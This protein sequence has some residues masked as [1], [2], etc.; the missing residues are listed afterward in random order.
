MGH[1]II[2]TADPENIKAILATQ[3]Q[4]YGKGEPFHKG[5]VEFL[6]DSIFTTDL[7]QWHTSRQLIRPQFIKDRVS[8]LK[9]FEEHVQLLMRAISNGGV[10]GSPG[11][12]TNG[13]AMGRKVDISDLL[14]RYTLDASTH[15]LLRTS[16]GSLEIPNQ[17]FAEAFAEVQRMQN[18]F[19]NVGYVA[20]CYQASFMYTLTHMTDPLHLSCPELRLEKG[21]KLSMILSINLSK[22]CFSFHRRIMRQRP[23]LTMNIHS[24][25]PWP[26]SRMTASSSETKFLPYSLLGVIRLQQLSLGHST[27]YCDTRRY[28]KS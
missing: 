4:D 21:S 11:T 6:G 15:F 19:V 14:Y 5:W 8:D 17:E 23:S 7:D 16:V 1:R 27:S 10:A 18:R 3:F 25:M 26:A 22:R 9:V 28:G 24:Y 2:N 12:S 20:S 13:I